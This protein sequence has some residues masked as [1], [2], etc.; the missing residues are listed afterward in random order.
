MSFL[1][2]LSIRGKLSFAFGTVLLL[3]IVLGGAAAFQMSRINAE[4]EQILKY[5][6][7]GV[8]DAGRMAAAAARFR[9]REYRVAASPADELPK[10]LQS[11]RDGIETYAKADKDYASMI[12]DDKERALYD[13]SAKV[14]KEYLEHSTELVAAA[15]AGDQ[16]KAMGLALSGSKRF[17]GVAAAVADIVKYN[18]DGAEEDAKVAAEL[19][20]G[21]KLTVMVSLLIAAAAATGLGL[22]IARGITRPLDRA[23]EVAQAVAKGDL[24]Q[25]IETNSRDEIGKLSNALAEMVSRLREI[26][27]DVRSSSDSVSTAAAQIAV[28]NVDL[29]QRTEE[30]AANLQQTAASMEQLTST[31]RQNADNARAASQL[32]SSARDVAARGGEV[33]SNVVSTMEHITTSSRKIADIISVIDGIAFRTNILALNAAVEAARAGEQGRGFAMVAGEVRALAQRSATAAKEIKALIEQSVESVESGSALV[34]AEAGKTM[35]EI[36]AQVQRVNDLVGEISS[37][38]TEQSQGIEQAGEAVAQLDKVTQQNAALVEES[39]AAA[40]SLKTQ[41]QHLAQAVSVFQVSGTPASVAHVA[42]TPAP[43]PVRSFAAARKPVVPAARL[44][45][46]AQAAAAGPCHR[47]D[48][49]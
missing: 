14:W 13:A 28:G 42:A 39:A 29:S 36:V 41:A 11:Y 7:A 12:F 24:T 33:V 3:M 43:R 37:A 30:Q 48:H 21:G 2:N 31:V 19:Y 17:D 5:R 8:R 49:G 15:K 22:A 47:D 27:S 1:N 23:V 16:A 34:V 45:A 35:S 40:D 46:A 18:N 32:S 4:T 6:I 10:V 9:T 38:S 25:R 44:K 26:V 20:A